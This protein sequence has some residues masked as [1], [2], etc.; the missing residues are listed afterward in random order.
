MFLVKGNMAIKE[1]EADNIHMFFSDQGQSS[2][3]S[4]PDVQMKD[5]E[6]KKIIAGLLCIKNDR[7]SFVPKV[8]DDRATKVP[9]KVWARYKQVN[10]DGHLTN[11]WKCNDCTS[12]FVYHSSKGN[13]HMNRHTCKTNETN[14]KRIDTGNSNKITRY[15][16]K[17][18][19]KE[20]ISKL[21]RDITVGL[22][23]DLQPLYR[24]ETE[25]FRFIAQAFVNF[26]AKYGVHPVDNIIQ[27]RTTLKR[28]HLPEICAEIQENM[29]EELKKVPSHPKYAFSKDLWSEKYKSK[30]FLSLHAHYIDDLW[31]LHKK[32]LGLEEFVQEKSTVNIRKQCHKIL[33]EYFSESEIDQVISN[34]ISVTDGGYNMLKLFTQRLPCICHKINLF[35]EWMFRDK[36]IPTDEEIAEKEAAGKP[37]PPIKLFKLSINC[38]QIQNSLA[39]V[40]DLVTHFKQ[41]SLNGKLPITLKQDVPTRWNSQLIML[42][43]FDRNV[44]EVKGLLLESDRLDKLM[45]INSSLIKELISFLTPFKECSEKLSGDKYPTI[46]LVAPWIFD[47]QEHIKVKV[48][49]SL[50]IQVLKQQAAHCFRKYLVIE[51][52]HY[53]ACLLD[54]R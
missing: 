24:S 42:E 46:Q 34:A 21:N 4:E 47:L 30:N 31:K 52:Y 13:S 16:N 49:D 19:H 53:V 7:L 22:A 37:Y 45:C 38:P 51:N 11:I 3:P 17:Q 40:K 5:V 43:S 44:N 48:G 29:K 36:K 25:G 9:S 50:E 10:L 28:T 27:H 33:A 15:T 23:K 54:P 12:L 20:S 8:V 18:I 14:E 2:E 32:L 6:V 1:E 26:G 35:I 39:G 41:S